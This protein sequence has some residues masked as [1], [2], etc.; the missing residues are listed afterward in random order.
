MEWLSN[1]WA[2]ILKQ[3]LAISMR[4][5][6]TGYTR[7]KVAIMTLNR[8]D[9]TDQSTIGEL[10]LN[11]EFLCWM[12]EPTCRKQEGVK[13]A[14]PAGKY[15]ITT[16]DSPKNDMVVPLLKEVPGHSFVEIHPGNYPKDTED[17]L[18][19]GLVKATDYVGQSRMAFKKI[20]PI[21]EANL[22]VGKVWIDVIGGHQL[23]RES[24]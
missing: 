16:Y 13:L 21:I 5:S 14:I 19:P 20:M 22:N 6:A 17:C 11:N 2:A 24:V 18:L 23:R 1:A 4:F 9:F 8:T 7:Y 15:E 12:L 3:G 10:T